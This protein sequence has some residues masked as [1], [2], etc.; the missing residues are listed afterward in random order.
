MFC[1]SCIFLQR[2]RNSAAFSF[3]QTHKFS[4]RAP[5]FCIYVTTKVSPDYVQT[6]RELSFT[7][8]NNVVN[9]FVMYA[10]HT[11]R[12]TSQYFDSPNTYISYL[13]DFIQL[14]LTFILEG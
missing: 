13:R 12:R 3:L 14:L 5:T 4:P 10:M 9:I 1:K 6:F 11:L 7:P 2:V 8:S